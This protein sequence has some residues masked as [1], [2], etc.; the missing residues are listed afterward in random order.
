MSK[1]IGFFTCIT[2]NPPRARGLRVFLVEIICLSGCRLSVIIRKYILSE[3]QRMY[4]YVRDREK[5]RKIWGRIEISSI[6]L[7][8][9]SWQC[10]YFNKI[11]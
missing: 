5:E 8:S 10:N 3:R 6:I 11:Y 2:R 4:E 1:V 9:C 7:H